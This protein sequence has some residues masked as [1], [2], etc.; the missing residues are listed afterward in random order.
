MQT[1]LRYVILRHENID[2]PHFDLMFETTPG[3]ALATWRS[4]VWP[5][6]QTTALVH[7]ADHRREYL[8]YEGPLTGDRGNVRRIE[9]G[10]F[11]RAEYSAERLTFELAGA[12]IARRFEFTLDPLRGEPH[13]NA[14]PL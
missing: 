3:A 10:S 6:T 5:I 7:L 4:D 13:W 1:S 8:S 12:D 9:A 11:A 2:A 14:E